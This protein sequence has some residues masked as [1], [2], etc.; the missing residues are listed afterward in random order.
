MIR[1]VKAGLSVAFAI[2]L[3]LS[4]CGGG[5]E[6]YGPDEPEDTTPDQIPNKQPYPAPTALT[7][8]KATYLTYENFGAAFLANYCTSCHSANVPETQRGGAPAT[9]N[10]D[11][12]DDVLVWRKDIIDRTVLGM[13]V[14][15]S[16][17]TATATST[18][19]ADRRM[20][21][22]GQVADAD[23][24]NFTE[25]MTSGAPVGGTH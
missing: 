11:S 10:F 12:A 19:P 17:A 14:P 23:L 15:G 20:P 5:D 18:V 24:T 7:C 1:K 8:P 25:W 21:P 4:A 6:D 9:A 16:T 22:M 13:A 3:A 2:T